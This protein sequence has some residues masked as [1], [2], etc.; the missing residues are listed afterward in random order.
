MFS[1]FWPLLTFTAETKKKRESMGWY[2]AVVQEQVRHG[3]TFGC[4][5]S[6]F[7]DF[8]YCLPKKRNSILKV[9]VIFGLNLYTYI[10]MYIM[11]IQM[12]DQHYGFCVDKV[13]IKSK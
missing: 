6:T 9:S 1:P 12:R 4:K 2:K 3:M 13:V 10:H 11:S 5:S 8:K 7:R